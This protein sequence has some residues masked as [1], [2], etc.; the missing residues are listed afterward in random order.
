MKLIIKNMVCQRCIAAVASLVRDHHF[1]IESI[2]LGEVS[3]KE[4][5]NAE[6]KAALAK[7]L[8]NIG[9]E[10]I[11]DKNTRLIIQIKK[12]IIDQVHHLITQPKTNWSDFL[13]EA[14]HQDYKYL[15]R[16]F[17]SIEGL[18]IEQSII[19]Q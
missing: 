19:R 18:T 14:L 4:E 6:Q 9:F 16:L 7:D 5:L 3:L 2:T 12:L 10:M 17:S 8:N 13:S 11:D 1:K 15:S